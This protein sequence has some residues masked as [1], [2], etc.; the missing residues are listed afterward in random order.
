MY[1]LIKLKSTQKK[2]K[3]AA[4]N[5]NLFSAQKRYILLLYIFYLTSKRKLC[6]KIERFLVR[7]LVC[8][9][10]CVS[11]NSIYE[12]FFLLKTKVI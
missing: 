3:S 7:C 10:V 9:C 2:K 8:M 6:G 12:D 1:M 11:G 4:I 5:S